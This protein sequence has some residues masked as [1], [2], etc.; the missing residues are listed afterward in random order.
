VARANLY[1]FLEKLDKELESYQEY[2]KELNRKPHSFVFNKRTLLSQTVKQLEKS[3]KVTISQ[4]DKSKLKTQVIDPWG[5]QL[6]KELEGIAGGK[7]PKPGGKV[8][9]LFDEFTD[10]PIPNYLEEKGLTAYDFT[11]FRKV[12]FAYRDTLNGMFGALQD[13]LREHAV[14]ATVKNKD[15]KDKKSIVNFY[16]AGHEENAGVFERF[17][18]ETTENI[19]KELGSATDKEAIEA[20][21]KALRQLQQE[22]GIKIE[23]KKI[24]DKDTIEIKIESSSLNRQRGQAAGQTSRKLRQ[25]IEKFLSENDIG[26]LSGSDSFE[27]RG[28]KKVL[29]KI[30]DEFNKVDGVTISLSDDIKFKKSSPQP[31][32]LERKSN[33]KRGKQDSV[34]FVP[35]VAS[36]R[37]RSKKAQTDSPL[38]LMALINAKLPQTVAKN[39]GAPRLENRT[40][41]FAGSAR[42]TEIQATPQGYPSIGYTYEKNPYSVFENTSGTRFASVERDPRGLIDLSIRE[43]AQQM[44]IGR[45]YT[46]RV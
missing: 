46:R 12:K 13:F 35:K 2:R 23:I 6:I 3:Q 19:A 25:A 26:G 36:K 27:D 37:K 8:T 21:N 18:D 22:T 7:I 5:D 42:V 34:A 39:M 41:R 14:L 1:R 4:E 17:L 24:D 44:A 30:I 45:F 32:K 20:R 16:D 28:R 40:G 38:K 10:V 11:V 43:I 31:S 9:L 15:G 29:K 33:V